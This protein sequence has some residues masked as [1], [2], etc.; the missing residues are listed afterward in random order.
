MLIENLFELWI[1]SG[2]QNI[3]LFNSFS[4]LS[5]E[6][7]HI[8]RYSF[9]AIIHFSF[10]QTWAAVCLGLTRRLLNILYNLPLPFRGIIRCQQN[11][12]SPNKPPHTHTREE[13]EPKV[14]NN[15]CIII[16]PSQVEGKKSKIFNISSPQVIYFWFRFLYLFKSE[17]DIDTPSPFPSP[18]TDGKTRPFKGPS[19]LEIPSAQLSTSAHPQTHAQAKRS[20]TLEKT[21]KASTH[22]Q[23]ETCV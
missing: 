18:L 16:F 13:I 2:T 3:E 20:H 9:Q 15:L 14:L 11:P 12:L 6:W 1:Y 7:L 8:E 4:S 10:I 22:P 19:N 17:F 23:T 5:C 21:P